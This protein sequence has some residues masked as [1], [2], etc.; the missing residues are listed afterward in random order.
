MT[1]HRKKSIRI[2]SLQI[3]CL[4]ITMLMP[5]SWYWW[6]D[7][8]PTSKVSHQQISSP[9]SVTRIDV[10]GDRILSHLNF[11]ELKNEPLRP[12]DTW[13]ILRGRNKRKM[14]GSNFEPSQNQKHMLARDIVSIDD[15]LSHLTIPPVCTLIETVTSIMNEFPASIYRGTLSGH[16]GFKDKQGPKWRSSSSEL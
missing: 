8:S 4:K 14:N 13:S 2:T 5:S 11:F 9:T 7:L 15:F 3:F 6:R 1:N 16:Q 12:K 10:R